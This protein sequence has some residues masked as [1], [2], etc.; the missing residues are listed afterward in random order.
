[1]SALVQQN[2][3]RSLSLDDNWIASSGGQSPID[4][5]AYAT[6]PGTGDGFSSAYP[7]VPNGAGTTQQSGLLAQIMQLLQSIMGML[8]QSLGGQTA[9]GSATISSTGDPHI[10][11]N[12]TT[13][14]G[15]SVS[16]KYDNMQSDPDLVRSNSFVGGLEVSTQTTQPAANGVTYNQSATVATNFGQNQVTFDNGGNATILQ[17]GAALAIASG[18]TLDLGNGETVTDNGNSLVVNDANANGG[19]LTTTMT[20]NGNGVDVT[21]NASNVDLGGDAVRTALGRTANV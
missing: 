1:M 21:V 10:A 12:G 14:N 17:N 18:Q 16:A 3:L 4:P 20:Q 2:Y 13:C 8:G 19:T 5:L 11:M 9:F 6:L 7:A 15:S